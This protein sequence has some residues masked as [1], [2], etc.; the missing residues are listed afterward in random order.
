LNAFIQTCLRKK[1]ASGGI[2]RPARYAV[3]AALLFAACSMQAL[4]AD[5]FYGVLSLAVQDDAAAK[6]QLSAEQKSKLQSLLDDRENKAVD[7]AMQ[8]KNLPAA[9]SEKRLAAFRQESEAKGLAL[10]DAGQQKTLE[11]IRLGRLGL[12][13]LAEAAVAQRLG[14]SEEQKK[15]IADVLEKRKQ[16]LAKADEKSAQVIRDTSERALATALTDKQ[17]ADWN[18]LASADSSSPPAEAA[19]TT[20]AKE[21]APDKTAAS[22]ENTPSAAAAP[23]KAA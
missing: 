5:D 21:Q 16:E 6:L 4:A 15:Q 23:A 3:M 1:S 20:T 2:L 9:E 13:S 11:R 14:L 19:A 7:L 8:L 18:S 12:A 22:V 10:L 17:K